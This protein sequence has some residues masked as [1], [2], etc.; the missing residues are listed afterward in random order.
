VTAIS[1]AVTVFNVVAC[2]STPVAH[3]AIVL[4]PCVNGA[5]ANGDLSPTASLALEVGGLVHVAVDVTVNTSYGISS[6]EM[7][8]TLVHGQAFILKGLLQGPNVAGDLASFRVV[9]AE[10]LDLAL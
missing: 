5:I 8:R 6:G 10:V 3:L 9:S 7:V 2:P 4:A 1:K